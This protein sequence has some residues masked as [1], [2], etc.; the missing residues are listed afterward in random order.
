M[1]P[2][3]PEP[4]SNNKGGQDPLQEGVYMKDQMNISTPLHYPSQ[5][6]KQQ[7]RI[8]SERIE[9]MNPESKPMS[10]QGSNQFSGIVKQ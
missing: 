8:N 10:V 3:S 2:R 4:L 1:I 9:S 5:Q 7:M 6:Q